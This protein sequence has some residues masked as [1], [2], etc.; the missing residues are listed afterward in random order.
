MKKSNFRSSVSYYFIIRYI[1]LQHYIKQASYFFVYYKD[2][3]VSLS[4][5]QK[6]NFEREHT[7]SCTLS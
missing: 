3:I 6:S 7:K 2:F 4:V 5:K 1:L